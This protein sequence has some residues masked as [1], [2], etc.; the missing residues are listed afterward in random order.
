MKSVPGTFLNDQ[1]PKI[2]NKFSEQNKQIK[3]DL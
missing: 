2:L 3:N 1:L